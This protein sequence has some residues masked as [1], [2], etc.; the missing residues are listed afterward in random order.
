MYT[1]SCTR[2]AAWNAYICP[3]NYVGAYVKSHGVNIAGTELIRDD[4]AKRALGAMDGDP[5]NL[6]FVAIEDRPHTLNL[7]G[8]VP[9]RLTFVRFEQAGKALRLSL[10]YPASAFTVKLWGSNVP[11]AANL[12]DLSSGGTRY[13]YDAAAQ[14]LH[15]RLVSDDGSWK[16]YE[17]KK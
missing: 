7:P 12:G 17:V 14:K 3:Y 6:H 1:P 8:P 9:D 4:G 5:D 15:L 2:K 16:E 10:S 11:K 13:F